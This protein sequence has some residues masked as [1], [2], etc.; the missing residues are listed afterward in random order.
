[1]TSL[2]RKLDK[3]LLLLV[4][5]KI[6][7]DLVWVPPQSL[8][9]EGETMREV[10]NKNAESLLFIFV[11]LIENCCFLGSSKSTARTLRNRPKS[12]ILR[13]RTDRC[14]EVHIPS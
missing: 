11:F 1:M 8:R 4:Q 6:G 12:E 7:K 3:N 14:T 9:A 10:K 5:Q 13:Q 2:E